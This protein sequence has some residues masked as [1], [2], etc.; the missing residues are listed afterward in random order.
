MFIKRAVKRKGDME[1]VSWKQLE[2]GDII[3]LQKGDMCPADIILLDSNYIHNKE[4]VCYVDSS[5]F[6]GKTSLQMK[7]ACSVTQC[8]S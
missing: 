7:T 2:I 6:D 3:R 1:R 4:A 5:L 8:N